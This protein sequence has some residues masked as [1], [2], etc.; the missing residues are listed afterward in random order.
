MVI[1][2]DIEMHLTHNHG[3]S[4]IA[5]RFIRILKNKIHEYMTSVWK[6]VYIDKL[7]DIANNTTVHI[8]TQL[9]WSLLM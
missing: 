1:K 3:K 9:K 8:I 5:E 7:D 4:V 2:N 6:K